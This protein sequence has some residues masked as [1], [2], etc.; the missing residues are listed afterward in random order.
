VDPPP[1]EP[2]PAPQGEIGEA[3]IIDDA[4]AT[5]TGE[6]VAWTPTGY[7]GDL[8]YTL[9]GEKDATWKA[10]V[11]PGKYRVAATWPEYANRATNAAF[12]VTGGPQAV[13]ATINQ[14][15]A[16]ATFAAGEVRWQTLGEIDVAGT[17]ITVK[18]DARNA[19]ENVIADAIRI[20]KIGEP[21]APPPP[22]PADVEIQ[23]PVWY[24]VK[25]N[26][27][28]ELIIKLP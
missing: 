17:E 9:G 8:H 10:T 21:P 23:I 19:D 28:K 5:Y 20:T 24:R 4:A 13:S 18:L 27:E 15:L 12:T 25:A 14:E 22:P 3:V 2:L 16:P 26:G 1:T 11:T 7:G 6:W